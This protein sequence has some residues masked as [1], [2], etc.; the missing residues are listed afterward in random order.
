M[1]EPE[2][3]NH[4]IERVNQTTRNGKVAQGTQISPRDGQSV[5]WSVNKR[6]M[7]LYQLQNLS[8]KF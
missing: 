6:E 1:D 4:G 8:I 3:Q 2:S 7:R 5:K